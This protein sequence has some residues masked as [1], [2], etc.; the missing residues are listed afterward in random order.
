VRALCLGQPF[1][2]H[3][4]GQV[5]SAT[6]TAAM[7]S[8]YEVEIR[9]RALWMAVSVQ[10]QQLQQRFAGGRARVMRLARGPQGKID[11]AAEALHAGSL[12]W[13]E[14]ADPNLAGA[15]FALVR[16]QLP[17]PLASVLRRG[18]DD[19]RCRRTRVWRASTFCAAWTHQS[20]HSRSFST[21]R[22][23][24]PRSMVPPSHLLRSRRSQRRQVKEAL[25][26]D[27]FN[28]DVVSYMQFK[29]LL[30]A[31][32]RADEMATMAQAR[33]CSLSCPRR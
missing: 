32:T 21:R 8:P 24:P 27:P 25:A 22:A 26:V 31:A 33:A 3:H 20:T 6:H 1:P 13:P 7:H 23:R 29:R 12:R 14:Q 18:G 5:L 2:A 4:V 28:A 9:A 16:G 15:R 30:A 11:D 10:Q 19:R 17:A